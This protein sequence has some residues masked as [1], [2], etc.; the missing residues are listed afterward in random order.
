MKTREILRRRRNIAG[1]IRVLFH[2]AALPEEREWGLKVV[3]GRLSGGRADRTRSVESALGLND[4]RQKAVVPIMSYML[5]DYD[6]AGQVTKSALIDQAREALVDPQDDYYDAAVAAD[7]TLWPRG[8]P[9]RTQ[10]R[11]IFAGWTLEDIRNAA[12]EL[13]TGSETL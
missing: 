12:E 5:R 9:A 7:P 3:H 10:F 1:M 4:R 13:A 8:I 11:A 2:H 6:Q